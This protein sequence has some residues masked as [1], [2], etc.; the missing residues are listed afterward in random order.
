MEFADYLRFFLALIF[1]LSLIGLLAW[2]GRRLGAFPGIPKRQ[3][4][5]R[6]LTTIETVALD[7]RRRMV[8]VRRDDVEHLVLLGAT[9]E[10]VVET[11]IP[12]PAADVS[13]GRL[14]EP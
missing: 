13:T 4:G 3:Q 6:R 10:T 8:L 2:M 11:G 5:Q 1:V 9:T 14:D 7:G 12:A